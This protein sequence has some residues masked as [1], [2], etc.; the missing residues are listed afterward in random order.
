VAAL[1]AFVVLAVALVKYGAD[2]Y[3]AWNQTLEL[4]AHWR[5]PHES[6]VL[7]P[8]TDFLLSSPTS[9]WLAGVMHAM[10]ERGFLAFHFALALLAL[11]APL[12][13]SC[14]Y[15]HA[16]TRLLVAGLI[17]A[18]ALPPIL[19]GW[20]GSYDP[21]S[22]LGLTVGV[23]ARNSLVAAAGWAL[24]TFNNSSLAA[25][26]FT[27]F[28]VVVA[29][30]L[31]RK[32]V[33]R[34]LAGGAGCAIGFCAIS[35]VVH[36]WG[37]STSRLGWFRQ[38]PFLNYWNSLLGFWPYILLGACGAGWLL[39]LSPAVRLRPSALALIAAA[40]VASLVLP[41]IAIDQSRIVALAIWPAMLWLA[42]Q[43]APTISVRTLR[44]WL[45]VAFVTVIPIVWWDRL[46]YPG[47]RTL[48]PLLRAIL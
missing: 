28:A 23:L 24:F 39:L 20:V 13:A 27:I 40:G 12:F 29:V 22:V 43:V 32:S 9:A 11:V 47:W 4:A 5:H 41:L 1:F 34:L 21:A 3:I 7:R 48:Q 44:W 36:G 18:S 35:I 30:E 6:A 8:P 14:V 15:R 42:V 2:R 46:L 37:G 45:C 38:V 26:A 33:G 25:V 16:R 17:I 19:L 31:R 10:T